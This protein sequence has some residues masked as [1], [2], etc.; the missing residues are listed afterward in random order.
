MPELDFAGLD[1]A[2]QAAFRPDFAEVRRRA[3]RRRRN[4]AAALSLTALTLVAA[5]TTVAVRAGEPPVPA[6]G[7][8]P[9][10]TPVF[11]PSPGPSASPAPGA[12][13]TVRTGPMVAGDLDHFYLRWHDCREEDCVVLVA[14]TADRG[15]TWRTF[16]LPLPRAATSVVAAAGRRTL[17]ARYQYGAGAVPMRQGWLASVDGGERWREVTPRTADRVPEGWRVVNHWL[18]SRFEEIVAADP[19]TGDVV[20][21]PQTSGLKQAALVGDAPAAAGIWVSGY[22]DESVVDGRYVGRGSALAVS[23]D[24]G[25]TWDRHVFTGALTAGEDVAL[26]VATRD[27]HTVYAVGRTGAALVVHRS[28]DGGRTWRRTTGGATVGERSVRASVGPDGTLL[29]QA[30][31]VAADSPLM[32]TSRD[33]GLS[34]VPTDPAP[35]AAADPV[36][37][38]GGYVQRTW[39]YTSGLWCSADGT[40]WSYVS[41]PELP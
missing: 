36:P 41:P 27:G 13:R 9:T 37:D 15:A 26:D 11:V 14:G 2:A 4:Q 34:L 19:V 17:V 21:V 29:V 7:T 1:R 32:F 18:G 39:P 35:G 5:A 24:G 6:P 31:V 16:P 28:D 40:T 33:A 20:L 12:G 23:R 3:R 10:P 38:G 25:R 8:D 22:A 30:G